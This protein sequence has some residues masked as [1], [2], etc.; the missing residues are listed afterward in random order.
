MPTSSRFQ[1]T[2]SLILRDDVDIIPYDFELMTLSSMVILK[3]KR[4]RGFMQGYIHSIESMAGVDGPGVRFVVFMQGCNMRCK[5]CHNPES[6]G[7]GGVLY[8]PEELL[9]KALRYKSYWGKN[10]VKGGVT[11]SGGEP[12]LQLEFV[13]EFFKL[14]KENGV[15]TALDTAGEPFSDSPE[16]LEKFDEL[17]KYTDLFLLDIKEIDSKKHKILTGV[18]N[19]NILKMAE[20][21]SDKNIPM[22]IRHVLVPNITDDEDGLYELSSFIK[23]LK[24]VEKVEVLPYHTLGVSKWE[25]LNI[26]YP[27]SGVKPPT[28]AEIKKAEAILL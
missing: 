3:T 7:Y 9:K 11:V 16:F 21:L 19:K 14:L 20:Y 15:H 26:K 1:N 28:E 22:W 13:T 12:L 24:T 18:D 6:W 8:T 17:L 2:F 25:K 5:F 4:G 27:L 10:S 23:K